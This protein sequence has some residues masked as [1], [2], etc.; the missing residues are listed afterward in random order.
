MGCALAIAAGWCS[1]GWPTTWECQ[2]RAV[3]PKGTVLWDGEGAPEAEIVEQSNSPA[4]GSLIP[5]QIDAQAPTRLMA[6]LF[7]FL[8]ALDSGVASVGECHD[9]IK[10]L[11]MVLGAIESA[12]AGDRVALGGP[13]LGSSMGWH[14]G[15][16]GYGGRPRMLGCSVCASLS[17]GPATSPH[18]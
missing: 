3:G 6:P 5:A 10:T 15:R 13:M 14:P 17:C 12:A 9:N 4:G 8:R 1:H 18:R 2:W 16:T 7:Q 11:A